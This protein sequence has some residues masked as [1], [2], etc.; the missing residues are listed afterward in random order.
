MAATTTVRVDERTHRILRDLARE[1]GE[2]LPRV[3]ARLAEAERRRRLFEEADRAYAALQADP[4]AW[5][6]ELAE[7]RLWENTLGDGL[8]EDDWSPEPAP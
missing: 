7:R 5:Q 2:A 3:L 8:D 6:E 1:Q 4:E